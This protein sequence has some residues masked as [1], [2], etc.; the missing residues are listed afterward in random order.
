MPGWSGFTKEQIVSMG[1][2]DALRNGSADL[3]GIMS[4]AV[5]C[6]GVTPA[7]FNLAVEHLRYIGVVRSAPRS[8]LAMLRRTP[9]IYQL[10]PDIVDP[11]YR[12]MNY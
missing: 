7:D 3:D 2:V 4:R 10:N 8:V 6:S 11:E 1:V 9:P 12:A 5:V